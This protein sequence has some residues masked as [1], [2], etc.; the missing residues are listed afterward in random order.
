MIPIAR[1][2]IGPEEKAAVL[3]VLDSGQLTQGAVVA[4]FEEEFAA[5]CGGRYAIATSSGTAA[6]YLA[7]LAHGIGPGDEVITTPFSFI[8]TANS[9]LA[10]GARPVFVDIQPDTF[11]LDPRQVA[12]ALTPR[13]QAILPVH[14]FGQ[15]ADLAEL[16]ALARRH[17]LALIEDCCQAHGALY[18]GQ[19]VGSFGTGCFSFYPTKNMTTGEGGM[20]TTND[21]HVAER[22]RLLRAHGMRQRYHHETVGF[23]FR[24]TDLQAAIGLVQLRRLAEFTQRRQ[25]N[26][27]YLTA[28][29]PAPL[30]PPAVRPDRTHVFHQYT[31]RVP[32]RRDALAAALAR[33]GV[34]TGVYYPVPIHQQPPYRERGYGQSL[35]VA[36]QAS[37][38]VLSRPVH[39]ALTPDDRERIVA[40][41]REGVAEVLQP[42]EMSAVHDS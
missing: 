42:V 41:L 39:P 34:G 7:L 10:T 17:R 33:R 2:L 27:A 14:L 30:M 21:P 26:A 24:L 6:L 29:L 22:V 18:R 1:P 16:V 23:N 12:A 36:E 5:L 31:I 38:C 19:P 4:A 20:V 9:I 35:P 11:T 32:T 13:T 8:A 40:V 37:Q 15:P 3:A 28:H 25:A